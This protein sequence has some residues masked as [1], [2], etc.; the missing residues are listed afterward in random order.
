MTRRIFNITATQVSLSAS[1]AGLYAILSVLPAF[2]ILGGQGFIN[3][4]AF[5][6]PVVGIV[7]GPYVGSL[8]VFI[9]RSIADILVPSSPLGPFTP[10]PGVLTAFSSGMVSRGKW[11][12]SGL[13]L[14]GLVGAFL[15]YPYNQ[16]PPV[17]PYYVWLHTMAGIILILLSRV[18]SLHPP[19]FKMKAKRLLAGLFIVFFPSTMIGQLSGT[20]VWEL[21]LGEGVTGIWRTFG[22]TIMLAYPVERILI[23][24]VA[25]FIGAALMKALESLHFFKISSKMEKG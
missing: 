21:L 7:L 24:L 12:V 15:A 20:L 19:F 5:I 8:S 2:K 4:S 9:G 10:V 23:A 6:E 1:F 16:I 13:L 14:F 22:M 17:F 3:S 11:Y 18:K 25:C